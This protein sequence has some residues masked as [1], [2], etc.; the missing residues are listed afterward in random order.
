MFYLI[1]Y[2]ENIISLIMVLKTLRKS[3]VARYNPLV[4]YCIY[5]LMVGLA[6]YISLT[7]VS[8]YH[9]HPLDVLTGAIL[10]LI[11]AVVMSK[12]VLGPRFVSLATR[13]QIK[14]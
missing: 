4:L 6:I 9:H 11:V 2:L 10:G 13:T 12:Y 8:D 7:R 1:F 3:S 5:V 14:R